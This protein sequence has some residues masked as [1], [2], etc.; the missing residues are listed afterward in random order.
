M[1]EVIPDYHRGMDDAVAHEIT[2]LSLSRGLDGAKP[3]PA[4]VADSWKRCFADHQLIPDRVPRAA[5]V[6]HS[7]M[8]NLS[9]THQD[10]LQV[11]GPEVEKLFLRLVDSEYLV[12]LASPEGVMML[13]RCDNHFLGDMSNFG[14]LPGSVWNEERQGTNGV[15]TC[16]RVGKPVTIV[17]N[18]HYGA[19]VQSLTCL[20]A[21]ILGKF[22]AI[23]S[24]LNVT[25]PRSGDDRTNRVVQDIVERTARRI[26]N[27]YFG[28]LYKKNNI[29]RFSEDREDV[30]IAEEGRLAVDDNGLIVAGTSYLSKVTGHSVENLLGR[31]VEDVFEMGVRLCDIAPDRPVSFEVKGKTVHAVITNV[32]TRAT[33]HKATHVV[34]AFSPV[35]RTSHAFAFY[36]NITLPEPRLDPMTSMALGRAQKLLE[37]GL[38]LIIKGEPGIGKT[39]FAQIAARRS[40]GENGVIVEVDCASATREVISTA[41]A[42]VSENVSPG[43]LILDRLDELDDSGQSA[44]LAVIESNLQL[45]AGRVGLIAVTAADLEHMVRDGAFRSDLFH[46]LNGAKIE[47]QPLRNRP[48]L[49]SAIKDF[50]K[51]ELAAQGR[52]ELGLDEEAHLVLAN[53][54]WPGNT[55]ELRLALRHAIALTDGKSIGLNQL[56]T[57]MVSEIGRKDLTARSQAQASRIEAALRFNGGNVSTTARHLGVS[58]ATL[59]RKIQIQ[60]LREEAKEDLANDLR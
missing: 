36:R 11:A 28:R 31:Q 30:D 47:L 16:I 32:E 44:L 29:L 26:E 3:L 18:Q 43:A 40:F 15:G 54:H 53:Y 22:G 33:Q 60:K 35:Q 24:V 1:K 58:R 39:T 12:S 20:V 42:H 21:P 56:P 25:T 23:E 51:L 8:C 9:E 41:T 7:E 17:G 5:V 49:D 55:R 50:L 13:F 6:T 14:V 19:G 4:V 48:D 45:S 2:R 59:Y 52:P 37:A 34:S 10:L 57:E 38:S 46:R 27:R